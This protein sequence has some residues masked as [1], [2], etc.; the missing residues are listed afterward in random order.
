VVLIILWMAFEWCW[1][2]TA[3]KIPMLISPALLGPWVLTRTK[4][5]RPQTVL[6]FA[7]IALS[8]IGVDP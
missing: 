1:P 4:T 3:F 2:P 7:F 5:W 8:A 6:M